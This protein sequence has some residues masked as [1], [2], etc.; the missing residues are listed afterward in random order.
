MSDQINTFYSCCLLVNPSTYL[1][2]CNLFL[3]LEN[4]D[5]LEVA[6]NSIG[7]KIRCNID[8]L[9]NEDIEKNIMIL[10]LI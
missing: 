3:V 1:L 9:Q 10:V 4:Y 6:K 8:Y 2:L 7:V 5:F